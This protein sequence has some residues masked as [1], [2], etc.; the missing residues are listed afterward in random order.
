MPKCEKCG[1]ET[2]ELFENTTNKGSLWVCNECKDVRYNSI[3]GKI[4]K[5]FQHDVKSFKGGAL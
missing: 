1:K 4:K 2:K 5:K 3:R